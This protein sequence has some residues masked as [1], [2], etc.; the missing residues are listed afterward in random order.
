MKK[1]RILIIAV[2]LV[3]ILI[4]GLFFG[5]VEYKVH[6]EQALAELQDQADEVVNQL[7]TIIT[8]DGYAQLDVKEMREVRLR[9]L[10]FALEGEKSLS[11]AKQVAK[12]FFEVADVRG[13]AFYDRNGELI[14]TIGSYSEDLAIDN[15][16]YLVEYAETMEEMSNREIYE[17][18]MTEDYVLYQG[19]MLSA[20]SLGEREEENFCFDVTKCGEWYIGIE[21]YITEDERS[22]ME[23]FRWASALSRIKMR[24][25]G[26]ILTLDKDF[27]TILSHPDS[28]LIGQQM[29]E[30]HLRFRGA[31]EDATFEDLS[32]VF[33]NPNEPAR[34]SLYGSPYYAVRMDVDDA[35][36]IAV[37]P[38][39]EVHV[40]TLGTLTTWMFLLIVV[41]GICMLYVLFYMDETNEYVERK[42]GKGFFNK[43]LAGKIRICGILAGIVILALSV[44][45]DLV[46]RNAEVIR[47]NQ[48]KAADVTLVLSYDENFNN[49]LRDLY[50]NDEL[51]RTR[52]ANVIL[53]SKK[54]NEITP[55]FLDKLAESLDVMSCSFYNTNGKLKY[56]NSLYATD[57][58]QNSEMLS[59][60]KGRD[61][62][63]EEP[64]YDEI[65]S[66]YKQ[67]AGV[68]SFDKAGRIKGV[69][70]V[71]KDASR[72]GLMSENLS[73]DSVLRE[74]NF[75]ESTYLLILRAED[76]TVKYFGLMSDGA[77]RFY[78][79]SDMKAG[80]LISDTEKLRDRY[81]GN[82]RM[83][84]MKYY[85]GVRTWNEFVVVVMRE[86]QFS[87]NVSIFTI[88]MEILLSVA[89]A[90][91]L[92]PLSCFRKKLE[93]V[94]PKEEKNEKKENVLNFLATLTNKNKPYF[95]E[96]WAKD[97]TKWRD[98]TPSQ[99]FNSAFVLVCF[100][101]LL[102]I[103]L[104][105]LFMSEN[106]VWYYCLAGEWDKGLSIHTFVLCVIV[107]CS[108]F[109][110]KVIIHKI[111]YLVA[112]ASSAR[113]ETICHLLDSFL[114]FVL[115]LLGILMCLAT[116]GFD[117]K[118]LTVT[119]GVTYLIISLSCQN[120]LADMLAGILMT[121]EGIVQVGD[122]VLYND[123]PG[124]V[125]SIGIRTTRLK[126]FGEILSVRNNDFKDYI[127]Y[128][129]GEKDLVMV[130]LSLDYQESLERF[131]AIFEKEQNYLHNRL[132][133]L[134][135]EEVTGPYYRG[136]KEIGDNG[137]IVSIAIFCKGQS[138][139]RVVP[140]FNN[141]LIYMCE[142]EDILLAL[143][144]VVV[145]EPEEKR[146]FDR[147]EFEEEEN[148]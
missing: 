94:L 27:G 125:Y 104:Q 148:T 28:T 2:W 6:S 54:E 60:F 78:E 50:Q 69:V 146:V 130:D 52:I 62:V 88:V 136:V 113:G 19:Y 79:N 114:V 58:N 90:M 10:R 45:M 141:E 73:Y 119:S 76:Q 35:I 132:N 115:Y 75:S 57:L 47:Y 48:Q 72:R 145:H 77:G 66:E 82:L 38:E 16:E 55:A 17:A 112:R 5:A 98:K 87:R 85:A 24:N 106:S 9:T 1:K 86:M 84:G 33:A 56:S 91:L 105:A 4:A 43:G 61:Y 143:P 68:P 53:R 11:R 71:E 29:D 15:P 139:Y 3:F 39:K 22:A 59:L 70:V 8:N 96:R 129:S 95:E 36:M 108:L 81:N 65:T 93:T 21:F 97:S 51:I 25:S 44:F 128:P 31:K 100:L 142:R 131:V 99:K 12:D 102:S 103:F 134:A 120:I 32:K 123:Q 107:I 118:T 135:G 63:I 116:F 23:Y 64:L 138:K 49:K 37:I 140:M 127:S 20:R 67:K 117:L 83:N 13:L 133:E 111:L 122:F 89:F 42:G 14:T 121:I 109:F 18:M 74:V 92:I 30:L 147:K 126:W 34:I 46:S 144:Q 41:T 7:S 110:A 101:A 80:E 26:Y 137:I 124:I 40:E